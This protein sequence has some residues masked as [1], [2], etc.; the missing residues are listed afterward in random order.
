MAPRESR[1]YPLPMG[2]REGALSPEPSRT[3]RLIRG[4]PLSAAWTG[5][6]VRRLLSLVVVACGLVV[7]TFFI[8]RLTP[9][10]PVVLV[11]GPLASP[12]ELQRVREALGLHLP[13]HEQFIDYF[14][15]VIRGDL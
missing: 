9:G 12:A 2:V 8:V 4:R 7:V 15:K 11:T 10:D 13:V 3:A 1:G 5:F 14:G 6:L